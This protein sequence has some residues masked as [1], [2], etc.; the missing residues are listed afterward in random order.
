MVG[1]RL[2]HYDVLEKVGEGG[3]GVVYRARDTH[4]DRFVAIKVLPAEMGDPERRRRF[5]QE[6]K[7][8]SALRHPHIVTVHDITQADGIDFIVLEHVEGKTLDA[9]IPR[10]GMRLSEALRIGV[11]IARA[12]SAAHAHGIVHR[13]VKPGNIMVATDGTVKVLDF[14]LVKLFETEA[15]TP[16]AEVRTT[17]AGTGARSSAPPPTCRPSRRRDTAYAVVS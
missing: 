4:L 12:L 15:V 10:A 9:L 1:R 16:E 17:L 11:Q 2:L 13:D 5:V 8:A 3:M 14:G 7:A 6:A